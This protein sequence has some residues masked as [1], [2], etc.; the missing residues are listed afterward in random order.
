MEDAPGHGGAFQGHK[1]SVLIGAA[2][3]LGEDF[4]MRIAETLEQGS[5]QLAQEKVSRYPGKGKMLE[6]KS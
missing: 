4:E 5:Y 2:R 1:F 6:T 3:L